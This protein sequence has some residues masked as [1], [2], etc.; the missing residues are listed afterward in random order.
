MSERNVKAGKRKQDI[1]FMNILFC[2]LVIFIHISSEIITEMPK[3]TAFFRTVFS[4]HR[5]S[6]FVVQGF[7]L[8]SGVKLFLK[9][10]INYPRYYLGRFLRVVVPYVIW[11][12][13]YYCYFCYKDYFEFSI[14]N[15][16][17]YI[18]RGDLSAH[19]YYIII[20]VQFDILAPLWRLLYKHGNAAVHIAFSLIITVIASQYLMPILATLFPSIPAIDFKNCFLRYQI[21]WTAGCLIGRHYGEFQSYLKSNVLPICLMFVFCAVVNTALSLATVTHA[22]VWLEFVHMM[23]C[24]SAILFFYM[25]GQLFTGNSLLKPLSIIDKS[26]Y[27]IYLIHCLILVMCNNYMTEHG[28]TSL[29]MRFGIRAGVVYGVSIGICILWQIIKYPIARAIRKS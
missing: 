1:V 4:A 8:L 13:I 20:L 2:L 26:S 27:A 5:L 3:N 29:T 17:E 10:E 11:V 19:F 18:L 21:Y 9:S 6:S 24:M 28:I 12:V 15:L 23:Y 7:L 25:A 16:V 14:S 22:P